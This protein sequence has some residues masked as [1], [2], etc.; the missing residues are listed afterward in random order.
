M[1]QVIP[2]PKFLGYSVSK[3]GMQ[4]LTRTLALEYAARNIRVNGVG[5]GSIDTP[6]V[7]AI[8]P[9]GGDTGVT[10]TTSWNGNI[11]PGGVSWPERT[12]PS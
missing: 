12:T 3:G 7:F 5:P 9:N 2:K 11:L 6:G 10:R 4:N 1:H 8:A